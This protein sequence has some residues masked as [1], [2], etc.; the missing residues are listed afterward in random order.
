MNSENSKSK[1]SGLKAQFLIKE[2][3]NTLILTLFYLGQ[4]R[5][6]ILNK[7]LSHI[8]LTNESTIINLFLKSEL[9]VCRCFFFM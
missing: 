3:S 5:E 4:T 6:K 7:I 8:V 1:N 9:S 2:N